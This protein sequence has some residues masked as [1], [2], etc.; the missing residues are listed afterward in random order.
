MLHG[1]RGGSARFLEAVGENAVLAFSTLNMFTEK[2]NRANVA[3]FEEKINRGLYRY[4]GPD[5]E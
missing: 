5:L 3:P 2:M 1:W 4:L